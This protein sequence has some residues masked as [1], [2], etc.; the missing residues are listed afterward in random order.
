VFHRNVVTFM[1]VVFGAL[2]DVLKSK[3]SSVSSATEIW[4]PPVTAFT[5]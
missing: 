2:Y 1:S 5:L 3:L 4:M